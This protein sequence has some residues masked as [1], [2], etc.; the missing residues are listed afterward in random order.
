M[1]KYAVIGNPVEHSLSPLIHRLFAKQTKQAI[2]YEKRLA[3]IRGFNHSVHEFIKEQGLGLNVTVPF[4]N[5]AYQLAHIRSE[6]AQLA[7]AAN[8]LKFVEGVIYA[9][10]FDGLGL[11]RDITHNHNLRLQQST[12]LIIG[13][14]GATQGILSPLLNE[15]PNQIILANRTEKRSLHLATAFEED[16]PVMGCCFENIPRQHYDYIFH[17]TS[18]GH[19][20]ETPAIADFIFSPDTV[21]YDINYGPAAT[22]FLAWAKS[23]HVAKAIDGLGMLVEQAALSFH[24]WRDIMPDTLPVIKK[25]KSS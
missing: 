20:G 3:P 4:K 22:P 7:Q 6:Q 24:Y 19:A 16:G 8:C 13:A 2:H 10:N 17:A 5:L 9:D 1:D 14:G 18:A 21:C 23:H 25:I 15:K 12:I 11:V